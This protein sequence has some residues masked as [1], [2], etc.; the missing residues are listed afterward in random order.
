MLV[1]RSIVTLLLTLTANC[2]FAA[3]DIDKQLEEK[4]VRVSSSA[5]ILSDEIKF[6]R[7]VRDVTKLRRNVVSAEKKLEDFKKS[8]NQLEVQ[9]ANFNKQL[10]QL[11]TQLANVSDV[12]TNNRL[13]GAINA[14]EG[15]IRLAYQQKERQ[16]KREA[17][18]HGDVN[19]ARDAF[20]RH[21]MEM[22]KLADDLEDRYKNVDRV[23][24]SMIRKYNEEEGAKVSLAPTSGFQSNLRKLASYEDK[25]LTAEIFLRRD[26]NT[27][28]ASVNIN[29]D[30][31]V[32]MI[33]DS[34]AS[35]LA[36]PYED[37]LEL[38][39][40]PKAS[41]PEIRLVVADGRTITGKKIKIRSVRVGQFIAKDVE[42]AVLGAEAV[43]AQPLLGMSF[44]G[45]FKFELD[46]GKSTLAMT[47]LN[48]ESSSRTRRASSASNQSRERQ[49]YP[50]G[51][52]TQLTD[53]KFRS[54]TVNGEFSNSGQTLTSPDNKSTAIQL[55]DVVSDFDLRMDGDFNARGTM[56]FM[57]GWDPETQSGNYLV[58]DRLVNFGHWW[59][60]E[61]ENGENLSARRLIVDSVIQNGQLQVAV[62]EEKLSVSF[63][64]KP[65]IQDFR[66]SRYR[67]G[68]VVYGTHPNR[69][70]G[71][72]V[73]LSSV[74]I[75]E[76]P[77]Q[78]EVGEVA[79]LPESDTYSY[80]KLQEVYPG[81][82]I[83]PPK[84]FPT[85]GK[86]GDGKPSTASHVLEEAD[87]R[88]KSLPNHV[89]VFEIDKE[90]EN[91]E[92]T[93]HGDFAE[94]GFFYC[95]VGWDQ[96]T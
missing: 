24:A 75:N 8:L 44:L 59:I 76:T 78:R 34:G 18:V 37:A 1:Q 96:E 29:E 64:G 13:V 33:V 61:Y 9:I 93:M 28:W 40:K 43:N 23:I 95:L 31:T 91:F 27:Y 3:D 77:A 88:L 72:V 25:V 82:V 41:D 55:S 80:A 30:K 57:L 7:Q 47:D 62:N 16:E 73:R 36:L 10:T 14:L 2:V 56:F 85:M 90:A 70:R 63:N 19:K 21:I 74:T 11:N 86:T 39:L 35:I 89:T 69:Y 17:E 48:A 68:N 53:M 81:G 49:I 32:E 5:A 4:G 22:R 42:C 52:V 65:I 15:R 60:H 54:V 84:I 20:I 83:S 46:A 92:L 6:N 58:Y 50:G 38:G 26:R 66:L 67:P 87:D 71:K 51:E 79:M 45:N 12:V 94:K